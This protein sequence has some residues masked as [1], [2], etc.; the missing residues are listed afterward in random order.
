MKYICEYYTDPFFE[1]VK[2]IEADEIQYIEAELAYLA[3]RDL[4]TY[5]SISYNIQFEGRIIGGGCIGKVLTHEKH[6]FS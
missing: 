4:P 3:K 1:N 5:Q 2:T 6:Y